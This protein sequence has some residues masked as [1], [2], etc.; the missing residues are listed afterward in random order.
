[1]NMSRVPI[2]SMTL[3]IILFVA[4]GCPPKPAD[5]VG[6]HVR[7][8]GPLSDLTVESVIR[9]APGVS[10]VEVRAPGPTYSLFG[11]RLPDRSSISFQSPGLGGADIGQF[12]QDIHP[13]KWTT[14]VWGTATWFNG[15]PKPTA[16]Q[17]RMASQTL[18]N[19]LD[20]MLQL[21]P[22]TGR[23]ESAPIR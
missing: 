23:L 10:D 18:Q 19:L 14:D 2:L 17:K 15:R 13:S 22:S 9:A 8:D 1:M 16:E 20:R 12:S 4:A 7:L 21:E 11:K 3:M 6:V 5:Q